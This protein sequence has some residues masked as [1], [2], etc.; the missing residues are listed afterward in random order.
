MLRNFPGNVK[1][2]IAILMLLNFQTKL[3]T[4]QMGQLISYHCGCYLSVQVMC[5]IYRIQYLAC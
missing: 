1:P 2:D 5:W 3:L 4:L